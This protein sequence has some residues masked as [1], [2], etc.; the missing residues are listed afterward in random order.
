MIWRIA[1]RFFTI[2]VLA[3]LCLGVVLFLF[4]GK[5]IYFPDNSE[6]D[7]CAEFA[8]A[9]KI[10]VN[11]TRGYFKKNSDKLV[12]FY[13][14][15]AGSACDRVFLESIF[16]QIKVSYIFV[17]YAGYAGDQRKPNIDLILQDARNINDFLKTQ[18]FKQLTLAGESLGSAVAT[19]HS[20]LV[21]ED[22]LLLITPFDYI[23]NVAQKHYPIYPISLLL[24]EDYNTLEWANDVNSIS[25]IHGTNDTIIPIVFAKN[26][27]DRINTTD[28]IFVEISS[29]GHND[30]FNFPKSTSAMIDY[31]K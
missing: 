16:D 20:S 23:A 25:I 7:S 9:E 12:V 1:K 2:I 27:Y 8:D 22:K 17:E 14:G 4:Q 30:L 3:Y 19:Y 15:N 10:N 26:L 21:K 29:A 18:E 13:H 5:Y 6:F 24:R 11:G 28:K 31:L